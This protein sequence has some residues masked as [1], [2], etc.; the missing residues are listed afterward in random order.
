M[1]F[2]S[3][4]GCPRGDTPSTA[5]VIAMRD[6]KA[7]IFAVGTT[8]DHIAPWRSVY[9]V[10]LFSDTDVTFALV[11]GGHNVGIVNPPSKAKGSF[12]LMT[13]Q[14]GERYLDPDTWAASAP[15][16]EGSWWP[17]WEAWLRACG[18][19]EQVRPPAPGAPQEGYPPLGGAPGFYVRGR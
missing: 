15:R 12:Q 14:H 1:A 11:S 9:N 6:I 10:S 2:I 13:R 18:S 3:R 7:P 8:S 16:Q 5:G 4:I 19:R 17:A